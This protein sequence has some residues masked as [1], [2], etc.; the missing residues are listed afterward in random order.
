MSSDLPARRL[1]RDH[2]D[3]PDALERP[4]PLHVRIAVYL[5]HHQLLLGF[6]TRI[7]LKFRNRE[8]NIHK[9]ASGS[10][11]QSRHVGSDAGRIH[12]CY[13]ADIRDENTVPVG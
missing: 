10:E 12:A 2:L 9:G 4:K 3:V 1:P 8:D 5:S 13:N 11:S 7:F 6:E